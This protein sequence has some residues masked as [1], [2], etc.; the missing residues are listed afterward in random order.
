MARII[1]DPKSFGRK[2]Q[3]TRVRTLAPRKEKKKH[4]GALEDLELVGKAISLAGDLAQNP[5]V[6]LLIQAGKAAAIKAR[7]EERDELL[8]MEE[9]GAEK[10]EKEARAM[11][12]GLPR[13]APSAEMEAQ[14]AALMQEADYTGGI[15]SAEQQLGLPAPAMART[16]ARPGE[17]IPGQPPVAAKTEPEPAVYAAARGHITSMPPAGPVMRG[18]PRPGAFPG[19]QGMPAPVATKPEPAAYAAARGKMPPAAAP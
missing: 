16:I 6:G 1:T 5:A 2:G 13:E 17:V 8:R 19:A 18:G 10:G 3:A 12:E 4:K 7:Q 14:R 11:I 9:R 15:A